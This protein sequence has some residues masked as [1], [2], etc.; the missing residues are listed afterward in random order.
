MDR[1][2]LRVYLATAN[3]HATHVAAIRDHVSVEPTGRAE[4]AAGVRA[5][6]DEVRAERG[7]AVYAVLL[8][9]G[10]IS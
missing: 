4:R 5:I 1:A 8:D 2:E 9:A 7:A 10:A 3:V 6:L